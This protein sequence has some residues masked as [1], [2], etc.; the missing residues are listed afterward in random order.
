MRQLHG[1]LWKKIESFKM[2]VKE[3]LS[4]MRGIKLLSIS[5]GKLE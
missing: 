2:A 4:A 5:P 1:A 3:F